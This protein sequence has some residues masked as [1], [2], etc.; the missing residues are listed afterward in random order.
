MKDANMTY[1][2]D[3]EQEERDEQR[4][5]VED[6]LQ[7]LAIARGRLLL[8]KIKNRNFNDLFDFD[9]CSWAVVLTIYRMISEGDFDLAFDL[10]EEFERDTAV[11]HENDERYSRKIDVDSEVSD[12]LREWIDLVE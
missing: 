6:Y 2:S 11:A 5:E 8:R 10:L 7:R 4:W 1:D 12:L 9:L 3:F